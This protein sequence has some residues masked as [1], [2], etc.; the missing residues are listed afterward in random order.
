MLSKCSSF[1][2]PASFLFIII[3]LGSFRIDLCAAFN[4]QTQQ[5]FEEI[6]TSFTNSTVIENLAVRPDGSILTTIASRP[7]IYLFQFLAGT[8]PPQ[9]I[10]RFKDSDGVTGIVETSPDVFY[11]TVASVSDAQTPVAGSAQLWRISFAFRGSNVPIVSKVADL[12]RIFVPNGLAT[13]PG[14][15]RLLSADSVQGIVFVIDAATGN[16]IAGLFDPLF[17]PTDA[18]SFGVNGLKVSNGILYFTNGIRKVFGKILIDPVTGISLGPASTI[19]KTLSA[20]GNYDDFA[21]SPDGKVAFVATGL[22]NSIER[23]DLKTG[24]QTIFAGGG[25]STWLKGPTSVAFGRKKNG[26]PDPG[27]LFVTTATGQLVKIYGN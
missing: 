17:N 14:G 9:L 16:I 27:A 22:G 23:I 11:V 24:T 10:H 20:A 18:G 25:K 7:E 13:L 2:F 3:L 1:P 12:R 26:A 6:P 4:P 15:K 5:I 21:V 19:A 8:S